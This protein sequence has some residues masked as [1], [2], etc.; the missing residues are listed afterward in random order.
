MAEKVGVADNGTQGL[1]SG[2]LPEHNKGGEKGSAG[3]VN[4]EVTK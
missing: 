3:S 2:S 1:P 4:V